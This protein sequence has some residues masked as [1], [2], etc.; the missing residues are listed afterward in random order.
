MILNS[1]KST[2][3]G[4]GTWVEENATN[5]GDDLTFTISY[6][7]TSGTLTV[8]NKN[9]GQTYHSDSGDTSD[10]FYYSISSTTLTFATAQTGVTI[11]V[12]YA[13]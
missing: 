13:H 11:R 9:T 7:P 6:S 3:G 1:S 12:K 8:W 2:G 4:A 10:A 5:S